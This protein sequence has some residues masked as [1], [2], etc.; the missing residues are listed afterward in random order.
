MK[1]ITSGLV[2]LVAII[3]ITI[4]LAVS[5]AA[6]SLWA[7]TDTTNAQSGVELNAVAR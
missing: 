4:T 1:D 3:F 7:E 5:T 6:L 2:Q